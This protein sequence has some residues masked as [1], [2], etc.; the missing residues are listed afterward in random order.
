MA[1]VVYVN[2]VMSPINSSR[3]HSVTSD[4]HV[5]HTHEVMNMSQP[6]YQIISNIKF[7]I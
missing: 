6:W 1:Q 2:L 5:K 7:P 3:M 4:S